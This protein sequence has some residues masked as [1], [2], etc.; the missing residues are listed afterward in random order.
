MKRHAG[1]GA[2]QGVLH[3]GTA[4]KPRGPYHGGTHARLGE[5]KPVA[6][7]AKRQATLSKSYHG[8]VRRK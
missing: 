8:N 4:P 6:S 7:P 2:E 3:R 5:T 1:S